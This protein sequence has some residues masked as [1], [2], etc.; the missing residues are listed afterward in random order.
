ML[1][2]PCHVTYNGRSDAGRPG[3][4]KPMAT[5]K[6][7][8][9]TSSAQLP[10]RAA[11]HLTAIEDHYKAMTESVIVQAPAAKQAPL[12]PHNKQDRNSR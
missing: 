3:I 6:L 12:C 4:R 9:L 10:D 2:S 5:R 8:G 11:I 7:A 1:L